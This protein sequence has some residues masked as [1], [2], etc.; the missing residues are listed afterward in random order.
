M[1]LALLITNNYSLKILI[2]FNPAQKNPQKNLSL[3]N[4]TIKFALANQE[5][6]N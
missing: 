3:Q 4:K 2:L 5:I 1:H 6:R